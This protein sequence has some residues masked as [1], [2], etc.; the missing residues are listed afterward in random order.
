MRRFLSHAST[1]VLAAVMALGLSAMAAHAEE[2]ADDTHYIISMQTVDFY[3]HP[4]QLAK[5]FSHGQLCQQFPAS[6]SHSESPTHFSLDVQLS[7]ICDVPESRKRPDGSDDLV[8]KKLV[9]M[10]DINSGGYTIQLP[11]VANGSA[12]K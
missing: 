9:E 2:R 3:G 5:Y 12:K 10:R 1:W 7:E 4:I 6:V 11:I 8:P